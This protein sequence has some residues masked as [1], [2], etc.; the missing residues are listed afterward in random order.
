GLY[1]L[2]PAV[3]LIFPVHGNRIS[4]S[5]GC[6]IPAIDG[7]GIYTIGEARYRIIIIRQV[8]IAYHILAAD[9]RGPRLGM[10]EQAGIDPRT[11][12]AIL[13][14]LPHTESKRAICIDINV[15]TVFTLA[16]KA[17]GDLPL[18]GRARV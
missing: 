6:K 1:H 2:D 12:A 17:Q 11:Y 3:L 4:C 16:C 7:P 15:H 13:G 9:G 18:E 5:D 14:D 10:Y 8:G